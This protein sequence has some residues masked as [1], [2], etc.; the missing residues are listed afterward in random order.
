VWY[1]AQ[2]QGARRVWADSQSRIWVSEWLSGQVSMYDPK[3]NKWRAWKAPGD[4]PQIYVVYVDNK[5]IVWLSDFGANAT[6]RFDPKTVKFTVFKSKSPATTACV[7]FLAGPVRC[8]CRS[9]GR[10]SWW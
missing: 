1:T 10:I 5:D 4:N 6:L 9:R 7:R 2:H 3:S 8:G